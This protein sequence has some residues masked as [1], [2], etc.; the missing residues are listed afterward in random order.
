MFRIIARCDIKGK[1]LIKGIRYEGVRVIGDPAEFAKKYYNDGADEVIYIDAVAS[2]YE[3]S[4]LAPLVESS[5]KDIFVPI[6][7]GGGINDLE[8]ARMMLKSG[9]EKVIINTAAI[10]NPNLISILSK[11]FGRQCVVVSIQAK[12]R[13]NYWEA[14][15]H[16]GRST[17]G[18]DVNE[19]MKVVQSLGAGEIILTS[20]VTDLSCYQS[21][22]GKIEAITS[23]GVSPYIYE[24]FIDGNPIADGTIF[25]SFDIL[26]L[27]FLDVGNYS[28]EVTD[29]N[30]CIETFIGMDINQPDEIIAD[31]LLSEVLINKGNTLYLT[32]LSSPGLNGVYIWNFGDGT[33]Q[34]YTFEP[35]H[36]Y[37]NQGT[38][39]VSL[40]ANNLDLSD[41]CS[42]TLVLSIEVEGY[43]VNNVFTPNYDGI[44]DQFHFYDEMLS[45]LYVN[46]Y[47]RWGNKVYH[48]ETPQGFWDGKG[49]NGE[50]L[51]EGVYFFTME[52]TGENGNSYTEKGS[53][54]LIR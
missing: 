19:W 10:S 4:S 36:Q 38:Y 37:I 51:P 46:I 21:E 14:L 50:L 24:L 48:W 43:D 30:D 41:D 39:Q 12:K 8:S 2:L 16:C 34:D 45:E 20:T 11:E 17:T 15:T 7:V 3:R 23:G 13:D 9:A 47:N 1:N 33:Q 18:L 27:N 22:D 54:T 42:D 49:Y 6:S 31:F 5:V 35:T 28:I 25:E 32:N 26:E 44:N 53:I 52:A 29:Y 40:I